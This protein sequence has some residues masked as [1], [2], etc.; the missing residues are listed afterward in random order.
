M[1]ELAVGF[2]IGLTRL[3]VT[4]AIAAIALQASIAARLGLGLMVLRDSPG[5]GEDICVAPR[6]ALKIALVGRGRA[7]RGY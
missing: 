2:S 6:Q 7:A 3:P 4:I 1:D 5:P